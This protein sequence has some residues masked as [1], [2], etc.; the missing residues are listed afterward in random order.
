MN[1]I[2]KYLAVWDMYGLETLFNI[3]AWE[4]L[5]MWQV[6]S[7]GPI[8]PCPNLKILIMRAM[9]NIQR[10]YEIYIFETRGLSEN[11]VIETFKDNPQFMADFIRENGH[12]LY[13]DAKNDREIL[14]K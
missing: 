3:T 8:P 6:L 4:K 10:K 14:I 11:D 9:A 5:Q 7:D 13:S 1:K 2:T 12:K